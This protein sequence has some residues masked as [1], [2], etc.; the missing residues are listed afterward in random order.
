MTEL[1]KNILLKKLINHTISKEEYRQ[2]EIVALNDVF[3]FDALEG[4][5]FREEENLEN[6]VSINNKIS[7]HLKPKRNKLFY[8]LSGVAA[9]SIII[10]ASFFVMQNSESNTTFAKISKDHNSDYD[11]IT[12]NANQEK[13]IINNDTSEEKS[14]EIKLAKNLSV[15]K[16]SGILT[17]PKSSKTTEIPSGLVVVNETINSDSSPESDVKNDNLIAETTEKYEDTKTNIPNTKQVAASAGYIQTS[18]PN[19]F[20]YK[21]KILNTDGEPI[22]GAK[23][24]SQEKNT[25]TGFDGSFSLNLTDKKHFVVYSAADF[26]NQSNF[27]DPNSSSSTIFLKPFDIRKSEKNDE[28]EKY[29]FNAFTNKCDEQFLKYIKSE[30]IKLNGVITVF[31]FLDNNGRVND[32]VIQNANNF[33]LEDKIK[34]WIWEEQSKLPVNA[35]GQLLKMELNDQ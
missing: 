34:S 10:I 32:M 12:D 27:I 21:G 3:L 28:D 17:L 1:E 16:P 26:E 20:I 11:G 15:D 6:I 18:K 8:L 4:Y 7:E 25:V 24:I 9:A 5:A 30:N 35:R 31:F 23:I 33:N 14:K 2:L 19:T 13:T 22:I 29:N